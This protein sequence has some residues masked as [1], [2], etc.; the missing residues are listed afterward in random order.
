VEVANTLL[1][2]AVKF[3]CLGRAVTKVPLTQELRA[4]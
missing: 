4:D 1:E 2:N 3:K